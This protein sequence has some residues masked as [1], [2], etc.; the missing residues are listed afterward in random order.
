MR[1]KFFTL[2][3]SSLRYRINP[4][5]TL[6]QGVIPSAINLD[7]FEQD[8]FSVHPS[9]VYHVEYHRILVK[10]PVEVPIAKVK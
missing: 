5:G 2:F 9:F 3:P 8:T 1:R 7:H 4:L 6:T 10:P